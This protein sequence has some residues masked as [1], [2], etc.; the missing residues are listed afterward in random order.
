MV[1]ILNPVDASLFQFNDNINRSI[2]LTLHITF[3]LNL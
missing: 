3:I 2:L 1:N